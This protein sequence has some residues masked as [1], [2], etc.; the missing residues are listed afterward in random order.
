MAFQ[1]SSKGKISLTPKYNIN[2]SPTPWKYYLW[3]FEDGNQTFKTV[4]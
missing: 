2:E 4:P 1:V 3:T